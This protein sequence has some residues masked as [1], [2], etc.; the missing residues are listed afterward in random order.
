MK[1]D[2]NRL[3]S[4]SYR[5]G[6]DDDPYFNSWG[7]LVVCR[8]GEARRATFGGRNCQQMIQRSFTGEIYDGRFSGKMPGTLLGTWPPSYNGSSHLIK[9]RSIILILDLR[10]KVRELP[11]K[12]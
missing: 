3:V 2:P 12:Y 11:S 1:N 8:N 7:R 9:W 4:D 5:R 6:V 10:D